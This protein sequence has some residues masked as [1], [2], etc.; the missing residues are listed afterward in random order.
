MKDP[1]GKDREDAKAYG[2]AREYLIERAEKRLAHRFH[3][4]NREAMTMLAL[5]NASWEM[6]ARY[7]VSHPE[8]FDAF[9]AVFMNGV[10]ALTGA[11]VDQV[12]IDD[13]PNALNGAPDP[14]TLKMAANFAPKRD[15]DSGSTH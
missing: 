13:T 8:K 2:E 15:D 12:E 3:D 1:T 14:D 7:Q 9:K 4:H 11:I 5:L 6:A 10:G